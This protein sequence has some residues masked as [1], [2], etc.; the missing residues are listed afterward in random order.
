MS[1][2]RLKSEVLASMPLL[3]PE[4]FWA[5]LYERLGQGCHCCASELFRASLA[6]PHS[7]HTRLGIEE[8]AK[9]KKKGETFVTYS[10][11]RR[12]KFIWER[13]LN[14]HVT[15]RQQAQSRDIKVEI[16]PRSPGLHLATLSPVPPLNEELCFPS[17]VQIS[18][19]PL[20]NA[21]LVEH[22]LISTCSVYSSRLRYY[23][24]VRLETLIE[25]TSAF[26]SWNNRR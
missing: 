8:D 10:C 23:Q 21:W 13:E 16:L 18:F 3:K 17:P 26:P 2:N 5:L 6:L 9:Q 20:T 4:Y 14:H 22:G 25:C 19:H 1:R 15:K 7:K 12:G 24:W 11:I